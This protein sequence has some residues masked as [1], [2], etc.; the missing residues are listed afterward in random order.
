MSLFLAQ[1]SVERE[2]YMSDSSKETQEMR[3]V[4]APDE[5]SVHVAVKREYEKQNDPYFESVR[6]YILSVS[7]VIVYQ[8]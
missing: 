5:E 4:E 8:P 3:L 1:V 2:R 7:P 6:A